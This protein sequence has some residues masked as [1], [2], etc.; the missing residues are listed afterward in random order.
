MQNATQTTTEKTE[1]KR[2][3]AHHTRECLH[4]GDSS[5]CPVCAPLKARRVQL[6]AFVASMSGVLAYTSN[7]RGLFVEMVDGSTIQL[8]ETQTPPESKLSAFTIAD[9]VAEKRGGV[10]K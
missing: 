2:K 10:S 3:A 1:S 4:D 9:A 8:S 7:A 6:A 5:K